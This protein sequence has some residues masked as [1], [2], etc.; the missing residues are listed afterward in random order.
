LLARAFKSIR[1]NVAPLRLDC[2]RRTVTLIDS[3]TVLEEPLMKCCQLGVSSSWRAAGVLCLLCTLQLSAGGAQTVFLDFAAD[4]GNGRGGAA[5]GVSDWIDN[6]EVIATASGITP[7]T[8]SERAAIEANIGS[9]LV[10]IY[11]A[12]DVKFLTTLPGGSH[13]R[14]NMGAFINNPTVFGAAPLDFM[15]RFASSGTE[16]T[17]AKVFSN[18]FA[19][20]IEPFEPRSTM[21]AE[22]STSLAGTAAHELGHLVGLRH[23]H[24]YGNPLITPETY[25]NTQ[26]IQNTH[27]M[28]TGATGLTEAGRESD[29]AFSQWENLV[30]EAAGGASAAFHGTTGTPLT[31]TG[32]L[33]TNAATGFDVGGTA[34][35]A[36]PVTLTP[37]PISGL[38]A[39]NV[40]G[41][42]ADDSDIDV[43]RFDVAGPSRLLADVWS[44]DMYVD[45]FDSILQLY[46]ADGTSL[47]ASIDDTS[48]NDDAFNNGSFRTWDS[49][50]LNILLPAAGTYHLEVSAYGN[51]FGPPG[52]SYNLLFGVREV[53]E[54]CGLLLLPLALSWLCCLRRRR[55]QAS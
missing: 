15:N 13:E 2:I 23:H 4:L 42:L 17:A 16:A 47:L 49:S 30:L 20:T 48:Y 28:A 8:P 52:G 44:W 10:A 24:A 34:A 6:L 9:K 31:T 29:R 1:L 40:L 51:I 25:A 45:S 53:P 7:F 26:G 36:R 39:A 12:Y 37:L 32:L 50:L 14:I 54:P 46:D 33:E 18:N 41:D 55:R 22:L 5:N 3:A 21:L 19:P 43:Y 11:A 35:T 27:I 38:A